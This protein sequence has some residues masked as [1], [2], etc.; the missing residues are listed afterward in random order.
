MDGEQNSLP[1]D[2]DP[3]PTTKPS[4]SAGGFSLFARTG[5]PG[6]GRHQ[7]VR[8]GTRKLGPLIEASFLRKEILFRTI[9][10]HRSFVLPAG[11]EL[12]RRGA[13]V[14]AG[15]CVT[16]NRAPFFSNV[17]TEFAA[18]PSWRVEP[19][20]LALYRSSRRWRALASQRAKGDLCAPGWAGPYGLRITAWH[21]GR[22]YPCRPSDLVRPMF[23]GIGTL[24]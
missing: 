13:G 14:P 24:C 7:N 1:Q 4:A 8:G 22:V 21:L 11:Q 18:S 5:R 16:G 9:H 23:V 15:F 2:A 10:S 3:K 20:T 12:L 17:E 19:F 6:W